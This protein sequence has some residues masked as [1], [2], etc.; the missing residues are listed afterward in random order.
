MGHF[1]VKWLKH[2]ESVGRQVTFCDPVATQIGTI[3][4]Y[5]S[6]YLVLLTQQSMA[7][8]S[9][10]C[11]ETHTVYQSLWVPHHQCGDDCLSSLASSRLP[12]IPGTIN[13]GDKAEMQPCNGLITS[14][15]KIKPR[16]AMRG[17]PVDITLERQIYHLRSI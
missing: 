2:F 9:S 13:T 8:G 16:I 11:T 10:C 1:C 4:I 14:N 12:R 5:S 6:C 15:A 7:N 17:A 3:K